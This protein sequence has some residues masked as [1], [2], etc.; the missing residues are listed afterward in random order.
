MHLCSTRRIV[1]F[2]TMMTILQSVII[3]VQKTVLLLHWPGLA[4]YNWVTIF[5]GHHKSIFNHCD[6]IGLQSYQIR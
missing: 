5:C 2:M 3:I 1:N 6:V 4:K